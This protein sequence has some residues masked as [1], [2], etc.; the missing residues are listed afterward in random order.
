VRRAPELGY[1]NIGNA[2]DGLAP[3]TRSTCSTVRRTATTGSWSGEGNL[4]S[5]NAYKLDDKSL[6]YKNMIQKNVMK[7]DLFRYD[8]TASGWWTRRCAMA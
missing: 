7:P 3:L 4:H 2:S 1:D 5:Y 8:C 6:Q